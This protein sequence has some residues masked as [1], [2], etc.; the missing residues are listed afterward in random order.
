MRDLANVAGLQP[1]ERKTSP[2]YSEARDRALGKQW[3]RINECVHP[4]RPQT[5]TPQKEQNDDVEV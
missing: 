1:S 2:M 5:E 3:G 4:R